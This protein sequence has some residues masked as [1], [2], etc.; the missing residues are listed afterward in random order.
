MNVISRLTLNAY[1]TQTIKVHKQIAAET[2]LTAF[3]PVFDRFLFDEFD[4]LIL[5]SPIASAFSLI[6]L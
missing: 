6:E 5:I 4:L 2:P 1:C 3:L